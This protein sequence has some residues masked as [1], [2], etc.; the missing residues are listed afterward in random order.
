M[1]QQIQK[2][3]RAYDAVSQ[4]EEQHP[5]IL[6][7]NHDSS[8]S[9]K[10]YLDYFN[11]IKETLIQKRGKPKDEKVRELL[12][13]YYTMVQ[14]R[15]EPV[16]QFAHRF[17]EIQHS[18]EKLIP[19]I[20]YTPDKKDTEHAF[21]IKLRP[22]IA[23]HLA[24]RDFDF[25]SVQSVIEIAERY[26]KQ[27]GSPFPGSRQAMYAD[28]FREDKAMLKLSTERPRCYDCG[29]SGHF[30]KNCKTANATVDRSNLNVTK[31]QPEICNLYNRYS[32]PNCLIQSGDILKCKFDNIHKCSVCSRSSCASYKR[33][34]N[35]YRQ[36]NLLSS[37]DSSAF[38]QQT[39][40]PLIR[41]L[42]NLRIN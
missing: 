34:S 22:H 38:E 8:P 20:H 1:K 29:K 39:R 10:A 6:H 40:H 37:H 16:S 4:A 26:D 23:K 2:D 17:L 27:F 13:E 18:L 12:H 21:L 33:N 11:A 5:N 32:K 28:P 19:N 3:A 24:S 7:T 41:V 14:G 25:I 35:S 42:K 31:K 15:D 36:L 9:H 30:K